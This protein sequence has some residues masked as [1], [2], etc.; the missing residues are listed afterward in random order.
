M[1]NAR[2]SLSRLPYAAA[3]SSTVRTVRFSISEC[4]RRAACMAWR[5]L[6][7]S[8]TADISVGS[9]AIRW[10]ARTRLGTDLPGLR[11]AM[12]CSS[13]TEYGTDAGFRRRRSTRSG[14]V[15]VSHLTQLFPCAATLLAAGETCH[16][17]H[18]THSSLYLK[19]P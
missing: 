13:R 14:Q 2:R 10:A 6:A 18:A 9:A 17:T 16:S 7:A 1:L 3:A 15:L 12:P 5:S 4:R 19:Y 11:A 8:R